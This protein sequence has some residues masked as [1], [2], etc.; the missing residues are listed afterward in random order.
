MTSKP[1]RDTDERQANGGGPKRL[2][3]WLRFVAA[4]CNFSTS[5]TLY[6]REKRSAEFQIE[7]E[8]AVCTAVLH[9]STKPSTREE[10]ACGAAIVPFC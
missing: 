8:P 2:I 7:K 9:E 4:H 10:Y 5:R 3:D 6:L 1:P